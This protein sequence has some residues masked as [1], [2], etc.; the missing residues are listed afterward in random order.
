VISTATPAAQV[1]R[2]HAVLTTLAAIPQVGD[3][4]CPSNP[5][6][7]VTVE[8]PHRWEDAGS[9]TGSPSTSDLTKLIA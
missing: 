6:T 3:Q 7:P 4:N 9:A 1:R 2:Q 5:A 8:L